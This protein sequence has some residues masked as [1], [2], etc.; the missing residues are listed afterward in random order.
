MKIL[1]S[2]K[3]KNI[4]KYLIISGVLIL[5]FSLILFTFNII[6]FNNI[7]MELPEKYGI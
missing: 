4:K 2:L 6:V 1:K 7:K 5:F 3:N